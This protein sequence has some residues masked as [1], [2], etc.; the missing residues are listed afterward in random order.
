MTE[1]QNIED[2]IGEI[3]GDAPEPQFLERTG[4][5][6]TK[7]FGGALESSTK[8]KLDKE[9]Y[10]LYL[11]KQAVKQLT[12]EYKKMKKYQKSSFYAAQKLSGKKT[13]ID[14]LLGQYGIDSEAIE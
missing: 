1:D 12:K 3:L 8:E 7:G 14:R 4:G 11:R 6:D 13:S 10:K 5:F 2:Q 9:G